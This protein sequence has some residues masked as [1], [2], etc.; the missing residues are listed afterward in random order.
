MHIQK[1]RQT[2][3]VRVGILARLA[4][5]TETEGVI[6]ELNTNQIPARAHLEW[7]RTIDGE[8]ERIWGWGLA[9]GLPASPG[10]HTEGGLFVLV[11]QSAWQPLVSGSCERLL[12]WL[13]MKGEQSQ[14]I[15]MARHS[16]YS[17]LD[18]VP[19]NTPVLPLVCMHSHHEL[20]RWT[21]F[22][23]QPF[24]LTSDLYTLHMPLLL[25]PNTHLNDTP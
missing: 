20:Y 12:R 24:T 2:E 22:Y 21:T 23:L 11:A 25:Y 17:S 15:N 4:S 19:P 14:R 6:Q 7:R 8:K 9:I 13:S 3:G 5:E 18:S 10:V 1:D 16:P